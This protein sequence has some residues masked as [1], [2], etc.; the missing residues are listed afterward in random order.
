MRN[1][2]EYDATCITKKNAQGVYLVGENNGHTFTVQAKEVIDF[3][4]ALY[5]KDPDNWEDTVEALLI[6][7][8]RGFTHQEVGHKHIGRIM[9]LTNRLRFLMMSVEVD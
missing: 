8:E 9:N 4:E 3:F 1:E 2:H 7:H 5:L 6:C